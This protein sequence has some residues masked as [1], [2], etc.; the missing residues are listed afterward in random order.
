MRV[1]SADFLKKVYT[2]IWQGWGGPRHHAEAFA[3]ALLAGDLVGQEFQGMSISG[4]IHLMAKNNQV[5][6]TAEPTVEQEGPSH[7]VVNGNRGIGQYVMSKSMDL[8]I[9]KAK[10]NTFGVALVHNWH[11]IGCASAY[12]RQ[13]LKEDC[14]GLITVNSVTQTAP[15]GGR[16]LKMSAAPLSYACPAGK[17]R[18][19]IGDTAISGIYETYLA[20]AVMEGKKLPGKLVVDPVSGELTDDPAPYIEHPEKRY[21]PLRGAPVFPHIKLYVLNVLTEILTGLLTPGGYTSEQL[22]YPS[23]DHVGRGEEVK[24]GGGAFLMA[25]NVANLMPIEDF[26]ANV[27]RWIQAIKSTPLQAGVDE[28]LLPGERALREEEKRLRDGIPVQ[29]HHWTELTAMARDVGVDIEALR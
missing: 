12:S 22:E 10:Q 2:A 1:E 8:A 16:E 26:K 7:V 23:M 13:A 21:A 6:L 3:N 9:E 17:E 14:I 25:I 19:L 15:W 11:D 29:E 24:R 28:I 27:D 5:N 18:A 4:I 20:K